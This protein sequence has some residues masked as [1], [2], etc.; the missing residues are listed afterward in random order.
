MDEPNSEP[1]RQLLAYWRLKKGARMAPTR[2][3]IDPAEI[4]E[5]LPYL[6]LVDIQRAPF[7]FQYRLAG[8]EITRGYGQEVT[9]QFLDGMDLNNHQSQ[10]T[11]EYERVA[12]SGAPACSTWEYQRKDGR[13]LRYERLALPLSSDGKVVDKLI[14]GCVFEWAFNGAD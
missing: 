14:G 10:I 5:L 2:A 13:H 9:G 7:R 11:Q 12:E 4:K 6:G 8:T 3:D 1:L